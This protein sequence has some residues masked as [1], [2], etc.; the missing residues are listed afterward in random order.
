MYLWVSRKKSHKLDY[1]PEYT[2]TVIG[3]SSD[4]P[5]YRLIWHLNESLGWELARIDN[6]LITLPRQEAKQEFPLYAFFDEMTLLQYHLIANRCETGYL[7]DD[8]RNID[9]VLKI[10][11]EVTSSEK[12][13]LLGLIKNTPAIRACFLLDPEGLKSKHKLLF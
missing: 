5:D 11:G 6:L 9:Y 3:I 7:L 12:E 8:L 4:E 10:T 2:F 1:A 13:K